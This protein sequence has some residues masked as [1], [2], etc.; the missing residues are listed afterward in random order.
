MDLDFDPKQNV[1]SFDRLYTPFNI[2]KN[3]HHLKY[4]LFYKPFKK[5]EM[6]SLPG[7][8]SDQN[9]I[10]FDYKGKKV[11]FTK[12]LLTE[13][14][15]MNTKNEIFFGNEYSKFQTSNRAIIDIGAF[16][17]D[18]AILFTL[19]GA[20][21][22]FGYELEGDIVAIAKEN[23][24]LNTLQNKISVKEGAVNNLDDVIGE[25]SASYPNER[26]SLKMDVE[27]A[28]Y[29]ILLKC[30]DKSL[31]SIDQIIMEYHYGYLN[32]FNRFTKLGFKVQVSRPHRAMQGK[33]FEGILYAWR[34]A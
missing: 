24:R 34:S 7:F 12:K 31:E 10:S 11:V 17:G 32:L 26:F 33:G 21:Y 2:P 6:A 5:L 14:Q 8:T 1:S 16:D 22:V 3:L 20:K 25:I 28:E 15:L 18:T 30:S 13:Q 9:T 27:G 29:S 19:N 4:E 23:I